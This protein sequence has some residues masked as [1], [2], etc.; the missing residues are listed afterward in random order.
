M[1][2]TYDPRIKRLE[3]K[4]FTPYNWRV[5]THFGE[6][7]IYNDLKDGY[8]Y[9]I[10]DDDGNTPEIHEGYSTKESVFEDAEL[11]YQAWV[12]EMLVPDE[13]TNLGE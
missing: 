7:N 9:C 2:P 5:Y 12:K 4:E 6:Y 13:L 11:S 1:P 8:S 3:W 10:F